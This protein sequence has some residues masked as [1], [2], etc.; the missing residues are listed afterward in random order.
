M[1]SRDEYVE[2]MKAQLDSW[3]REIDTLEG[4]IATVTGPAREELR[5]RLAKTRESFE[6]GKSKL[7]ELQ[8]SGED[9]FKSLK[10]EAEHIWDALRHSFNYFRSQL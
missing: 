10:D 4:R 2:K 7:K 9:S 6:E 1:G 8:A 3:N 5:N